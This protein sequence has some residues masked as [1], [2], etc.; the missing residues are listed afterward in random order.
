M[1]E[2]VNA[3]IQVYRG[4]AGPGMSTYM[5]AFPVAPSG[6]HAAPTPP[7]LTGPV[8][9][10][11]AHA[12]TQT[13]HM[14]GQVS[15][16]GPMPLP[17]GGSGPNPMVPA[18]GSSGGMYPGSGYGVPIRKSNTGLIVAILAV[19]LVGGGIAAVVA[20]GGDK[21]DSGG[22]SGSQVAGAED[23]GAGSNEV[24]PADAMSTVVD[25]AT[26]VSVDAEVVAAIDAGGEAPKADAAVNPETVEILIK[27]KF[28]GSFEVWEDDRKLF[29]G[30]DNLPVVVGESR[31]I[32]IKARGYKDKTFT[33]GADAKGRKFEFKLERLPG[34]GPG[35]GSTR[36][37]VDPGCKS[38]VVDPS[39]AA[40]RKQYCQF[41]P[42]DLR[43]GAE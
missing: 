8:L 43:C 35:S 1:D 37:P 2:L 30:P 32:T 28:H 36:P 3:L 40:C 39:S 31:K 22:G 25:A 4:I 33:V 19:V 18:P 6:R 15:G 17:I 24:P 42:D 21:K 5:E 23:A 11:A 13:P 29:D 34:P 12:P 16:T 14:L 41:H 26:P 9:V 7:P 20:L 27:S 10:G 38:I